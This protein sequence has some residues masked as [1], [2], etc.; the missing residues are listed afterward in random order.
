LDQQQL[1]PDFKQPGGLSRQKSDISMLIDEK[2]NDPHFL[3]S[4]DEEEA[5][6]TNL[7]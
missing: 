6:A 7:S 2:R 5:G 4:F 1:D 3:L